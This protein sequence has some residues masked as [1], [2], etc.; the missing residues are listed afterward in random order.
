MKQPILEEV[1][2][3]QA[4]KDKER[5]RRKDAKGIF[6]LSS[7]IKI[8]ELFVKLREFFVSH[9]ELKLE[10]ERI[11]LKIENQDKNIEVVF[12]YIDELMKQK[13]QPRTQIGFQ[14]PVKPQK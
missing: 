14:L 10:L 1:R 13:K 4:T 8:I 11:K 12:S 6:E 3:I 9:A 2:A 7:S 5:R